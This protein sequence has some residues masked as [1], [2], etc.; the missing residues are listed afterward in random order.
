MCGLEVGDLHVDGIRFYNLWWQCAE[1]G[2]PDFFNQKI[3]LLGRKYTCEQNSEIDPSD[4]H[5]VVHVMS[6]QS[7]FDPWIYVMSLF[8]QLADRQPASCRARQKL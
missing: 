6:L 4:A 1:R 8:M 7:T 3:S 2:P 5:T